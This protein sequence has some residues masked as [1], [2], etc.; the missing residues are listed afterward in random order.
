MADSSAATGS[1]PAQPGRFATTR[2]SLV[3]DAGDAESPNA[4]QALEALCR[5]YW[6]PLYVFVRRQGVEATAAEDLTQGFFAMLLERGDLGKATPERGRFRNYL[7]V[8]LKHFLANERDRAAALKRGGQ[9]V[10]FSLDAA[11]AEGRYAFEPADAEDPEALFRRQWALTLLDLVQQRLREEYVAAGNEALFARLQPL[12]T[13]ERPDDTYRAIAEELGISAGAV[14]TA[15]HRLRQRFG[16]RLR[17]E[18]T[19]TVAAEEEVDSEI[20]ELLGALRS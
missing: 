8:A 4:R 14:K 9:R 7:L 19:Q 15:A 17:E 12:L 16:E 20:R 13:G 1:G 5:Q 18:I 6:Y 2:W 11:A 3:L 10:T